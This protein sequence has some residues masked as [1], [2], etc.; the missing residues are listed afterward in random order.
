MS[1]I[2]T[3]NQL[4]ADILPTILYLLFYIAPPVLA[5][6]AYR[7]WVY[8][9]ESMYIFDLE[10]VMLEI[11]MPS[12]INKS[13][14]AMEIVFSALHQGSDPN[15]Y[16]HL[17]K[18]EVRPWFSF[19]IAS[20]SGTLHF[21]VRVPVKYKNLIEA[22][23]Y[24]QYPNIE[25]FEAEDYV[26]NVSFGKPDSPHEIW[27]TQFALTKEDAHPIKTYIDYGLDSDPKE[28]FKVD[29]MTPIIE[30]MG[31]IKSGEQIWFQILFMATKKR[32]S[33]SG[34]MF[35]FEKV[36]WKE[37]GANLVKKIMADAT[38]E[39]GQTNVTEYQKKVIEAIERNISKQGFDCGIRA[40]HIGPKD[41]FDGTNN[42]GIIG[43]LKQF[44]SESLNGFKPDN[45][46]DINYPWQDVRGKRLLLKKRMMY[47]A[48]RRRSYFYFPHKY[49]P[50]ILNTEE[51]ATLYHFPGQV[52]DSP[53]LDRIGSKRGEP[54]A[55]L[56]F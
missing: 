33:K 14:K 1:F 17:A 32:F 25:I 44:N 29:P 24:S 39:N 9:K 10:W 28:E 6:F 18:G 5:Y 40:I 30:F 51:L 12:E 52:A 43:M 35:S 15:W 22:Q 37:Q 23:I 46:T 53:S 2:E 19:E 16:K 38:N 27:G 7:T 3:Y 20:I 36:D 4:I 41:N 8:Y 21:Y 31:S 13:P 47:D 34:K 45:V 55:N 42:G 49:K 48:Y 54:P 26:N 56:P 50:M 11:K